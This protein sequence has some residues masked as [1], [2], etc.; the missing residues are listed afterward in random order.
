MVDALDTQTKALAVLNDDLRRRIFLFVRRQDHSVS[1]E[2]IAR[3]L[4]ISRK[5]AAF[6]LDKLS[7]NE[8]L[9]HHFARPEGRSGPGAGRP[10]KRYRPSGRVIEI[11]VPQRRYELAGRLLLQGIQAQTQD[12]ARDEAHRAAMLEGR[13]LGAQARRDKGL[14]PPGPERTLSIAEEVL[15]ECGFEPLRTSPDELILRNCPFQALARLDPDVICNMNLQLIKGLLEGLRSTSAQA[16][17]QQDPDHCCV[18]LRTRTR[19]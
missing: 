6:H 8:L 2:E 13:R 12:S 3:E 16:C 14:R 15:G 7:D 18:R 9:D 11:S 19:G 5:L 1:R 17:L 10:A 4:G